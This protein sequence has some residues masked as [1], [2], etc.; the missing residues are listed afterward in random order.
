M[1]PL[2]LNGTHQ[3]FIVAVGIYSVDQLNFM[4]DHRTITGGWLLQHQQA[5]GPKWRLHQFMAICI[6][7]ILAYCH[8]IPNMKK[9]CHVE[10]VQYMFF[11]E[12][13]V[14]FLMGLLWV[15]C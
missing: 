2:A 6:G 1:K 7:T 4:D 5:W 9:N 11:H 3:S 10:Q 14:P 15:L 8:F 13:V 12:N